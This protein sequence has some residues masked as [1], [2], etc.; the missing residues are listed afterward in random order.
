MKKVLVIGILLAVVAVLVARRRSQ[1]GES[2][3]DATIDLTDAPRVPTEVDDAA[4]D[5]AEAAFARS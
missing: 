5:V 4:T 2:V 1:S 3:G